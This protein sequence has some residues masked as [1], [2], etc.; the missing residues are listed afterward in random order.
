MK[1]GGTVEGTESAKS[2]TQGRVGLLDDE[3][4]GRHYWTES[5]PRGFGHQ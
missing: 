5:G 1:F 2:L 4:G 3:Q